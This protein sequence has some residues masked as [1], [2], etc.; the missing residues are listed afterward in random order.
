MSVPDRV[1]F[2]TEPIVAHADDE[3]GSE[4]VEEYLNAITA[5]NANGYISRVIS[6]KSATSS[7]ENTIGTWLMNIS[8]GFLISD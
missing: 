7:R 6:R 8:T 4:S 3:P 5:E 2:D 1:V